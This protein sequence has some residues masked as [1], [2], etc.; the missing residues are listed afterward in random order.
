MS[1]KMDG[2]AGLTKRLRAAA[3]KIA[4]DVPRTEQDIEDGVWGEI[5][6][7]REA[8]NAIE[9]LEA[10]LAP[11]AAFAEKAEQLV[12]ARANEIVVRWWFGRRKEKALRAYR[13]AINPEEK[14]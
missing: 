2:R 14:G 11:F 13:N 8:A 4:K 7:M 9:E 3:T 1:E 12:E 5:E 6:L 10:A